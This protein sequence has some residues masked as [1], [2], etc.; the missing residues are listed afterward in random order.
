METQTYS[1]YFKCPP[2]Q[3]M[4]YPVKAYAPR[5][6]IACSLDHETSRV[7]LGGRFP[8]LY[9][10]RTGLK[11]SCPGSEQTAG[12]DPSRA[13]AHQH[14]FCASFRGSAVF[15]CRWTARGRSRWL[16]AACV[17]TRRSASC[18]ASVP[19]LSKSVPIGERA[20]T[21][22][23]AQSQNGKPLLGEERRRNHMH[24]ERRPGPFPGLQEGCAA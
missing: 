19:L 1:L 22:R 24:V 10:P 21:S 7:A 6:R 20:L 17:P 11:F 23:H 2:T 12:S 4:L 5:P 9:L 13:T 8:S 18:H 3:Q 14:F 15:P 16:S